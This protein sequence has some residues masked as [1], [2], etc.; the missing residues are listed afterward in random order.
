MPEFD[1]QRSIIGRIDS[2]I[3]DSDMIVVPDAFPWIH[4]DDMADM[5]ICAML[6]VARCSTAAYT[7]WFCQ[8]VKQMPQLQLLTVQLA[9][10]RPMFAAATAAVAAC[11]TGLCTGSSS[12]GSLAGVGGSGVGSR[13]TAV[14]SG[15]EG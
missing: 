10:A 15:D 11:S 12:S 8:L 9:V 2:V 6:P 5:N 3:G 4:V 1:R 14:G 13:Q 7:A